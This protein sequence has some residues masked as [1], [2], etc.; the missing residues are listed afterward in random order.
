MI[1]KLESAMIM[2]RDYQGP[3]LLDIVC[4]ISLI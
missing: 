2:L 3:T 4:D 1:E